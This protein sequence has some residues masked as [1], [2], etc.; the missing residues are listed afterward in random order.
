MY[1]LEYRTLLS[2]NL[3]DKCVIKKQLKAQRN[4]TNH[5]QAKNTLGIH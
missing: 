1:L 5:E 3:I 2:F 4:D